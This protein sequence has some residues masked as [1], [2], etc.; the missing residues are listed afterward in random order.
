M[1]VPHAL[2]RSVQPPETPCAE[3][4]RS[5]GLA[6]DPTSEASVD[7]QFLALV[8][9]DPELLEA[10]FAALIRRSVRRFTRRR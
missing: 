3:H 6:D 9:A 10:E 2:T 4:A 5:A 8:L 7:E 1:S